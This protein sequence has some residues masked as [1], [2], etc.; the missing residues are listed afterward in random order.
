MGPRDPEGK[1]EVSGDPTAKDC[2]CLSQILGL[3]SGADPTWWFCTC[4]GNT[5][6]SNCSGAAGRPWS[7]AEGW[8]G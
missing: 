1:I 2:C 4:A 3:K 7:L 6:L 8:E 5:V